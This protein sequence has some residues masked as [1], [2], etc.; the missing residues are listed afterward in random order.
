MSNVNFLNLPIAVGLDGSEWV[1]LSQSG[2]AKRATTSQVSNVSIANNIPASMQFLIDGGGVNIMSQVWGYE[3]VPF[4]ASIVGAKLLADQVGSI[5]VNIWKCT[6]AQFDGGVT[7]PVAGDSITGG[8]PPTITVGTKAT[9][10]LTDWTTGLTEGDVLAFQ[11]PTTAS[12]I[13]R[14]TLTLELL[15]VIV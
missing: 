2:T 12:G 13:T 14:V 1:P 5:T 6:Y 3:E 4:D 8:A 10:V 7:H 9:A 15:R 11:V